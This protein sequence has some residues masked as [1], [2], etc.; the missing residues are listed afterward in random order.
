MSQGMVGPSP[1]HREMLEFASRNAH[2]NRNA[3]NV[4]LHHTKRKACQAGL[5]LFTE[6]QVQ[7]EKMPQPCRERV[8]TD[9]L[10]ATQL[11]CVEWRV[12]NSSVNVGK[13]NARD[14]HLK[15]R[16]R[17]MERSPSR[18]K[19]PGVQDGKHT[20]H[21]ARPGVAVTSADLACWYWP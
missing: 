21:P 17:C 2:A 13:L 12:L 15:S 9:L 10:L 14:G 11:G 1:P 8:F 16:W 3:R 7:L 6:S 18:R 5:V 4:F 20:H 19:H